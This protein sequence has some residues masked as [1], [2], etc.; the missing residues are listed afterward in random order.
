MR[1]KEVKNVAEK[2][3]LGLF[4]NRLLSPPFGKSAFS[5]LDQKDL[6]VEYV[7]LCLGKMIHI[8]E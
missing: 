6:F 1:Q 3:K 5:L 4:G 7:Y 2:I 8:A